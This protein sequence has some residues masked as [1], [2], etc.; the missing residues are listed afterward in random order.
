MCCLCLAFNLAKNP[1]I[2]K[3]LATCNNPVL[4][5][6]NVT[7]EELPLK[8]E[9][10]H[11]LR[12]NQVDLTDLVCRDEVELPEEHS[13]TKFVLVDH[14]VSK[15]RRN[16]IAVVDHRPLDGNSGL[17]G[18]TFKFI[19]QVGSCAT[20]VA[21]LM[22]QV[23][24]FKEVA[25]ENAD[26]LRLLYGAIVLDTVNFSAEADRARPLDHEMAALIERGLR[27]AD[28]VA[29]RKQLFDELVAKRGDVSS[30]DSLQ[31]LSKDLKIVSKNGITVAIPGY[32]ILVQEYVKLDGVA[33]NLRKF[34]DKTN[35]NVIVLMGMK[36][37]DGSVQRDLGI[38]NINN[39][40]LHQEVNL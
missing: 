33:G 9:V 5:V 24:L 40:K 28:S 7:R 16:V 4:P 11:F 8:T 38:I 34:A 35:S 18:G 30:L 37:T 15:F 20:L 27:V 22:E 36:V 25:E 29:H 6:L 21:K 31:I 19:E 39:K 23:D 17:E 3:S 13:E 10:V 2:I 32:P 26:V 12:S 1:G 14:H